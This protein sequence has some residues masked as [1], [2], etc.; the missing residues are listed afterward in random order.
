MAT[1][2]KADRSEAAKKAAATR[3]RNEVRAESKQQGH[4]AAASRF[5][6]D[7]VDGLK[8]AR[9]EAEKATGSV[10]GAAKSVGGAA[11][12]AGRSVAARVGI[13]GKK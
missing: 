11:V 4:K 1:Q 7:A 8:R 5:Q 13:G 9:K 3:Q 10:T 6:N 12:S 2:T